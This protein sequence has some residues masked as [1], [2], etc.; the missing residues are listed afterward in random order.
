[1]SQI[2]T[3]GLAAMQG[4]FGF[5][6][7]KNVLSLAI[8]LD[9]SLGN[10]TPYILNLADVIETDKLEFVQ[11]LYVDN[12]ANPA[13]ISF[14]FTV[15]Q[16]KITIPAQSQGYIPVLS[17]N[18]PL[19]SVSTTG[20][21]TVRVHFLNAPYPAAIWGGIGSIAVS[22]DGS[23]TITTGGTAQPLFASV[24]PSTGFAVYNPDAANDLWISDGGTAAANAAGSIRI[25]AN[26]GWYESPALRRP[27]GIVSIVGAVNGQKFTAQRW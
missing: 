4:F 1:M 14:T 3:Q 20:T 9:F 2:L 7:K 12:S 15:S 21:P 24:I 17:P 5:E 16:Q 6:P 25:P 19:I 23:G 13:S 27:I 11:T 26:G 8:D 22:L 10:A 18:P